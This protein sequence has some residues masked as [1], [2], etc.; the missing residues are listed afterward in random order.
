MILRLIGYLAAIASILSG[1]YV[2]QDKSLVILGIILGGIYMI[3]DC[4]ERRMK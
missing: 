3:L 1:I 4:I 2:Y